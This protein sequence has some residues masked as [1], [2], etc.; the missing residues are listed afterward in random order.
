MKKNMYVLDATML[1][2]GLPYRQ[3]SLSGDQLER[4]FLVHEG[5]LTRKPR[6]IIAQHLTGVPHTRACKWVRS[7]MEHRKEKKR[8]KGE[9]DITGQ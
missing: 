2:P 5:I 1:L 9:K 8:Q 7:D 4:I 6:P 3:H